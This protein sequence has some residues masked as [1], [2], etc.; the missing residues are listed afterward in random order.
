MKKTVFLTIAILAAITIVV[1][2]TAQ[3]K[4][5]VNNTPTSSNWKTYTNTNLNLSLQYPADW[6]VDSSQALQGFLTIQSAP[7]DLDTIQTIGFFRIDTNRKNVQRLDPQA[8]FM[9]V[10]APNVDTPVS[11]AVMT[12]N[13]L[14]AYT[15]TTNEMSQLRHTF[16]FDGTRVVEIYYPT[17]NPQLQ[18]T[19]E[20][21][22]NSLKIN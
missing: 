18:S 17:D 22:A 7:V 19:Y 3:T 4:N 6:T 12:V 15:V 8:W 16:I 9:Q 11:S 5:V 21:M 2:A 1:L 14:P 13:K 10:M 20:T